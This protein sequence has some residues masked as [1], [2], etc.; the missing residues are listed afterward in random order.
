MYIHVP[1]KRKFSWQYLIKKI[2]FTPTQ[3]T[4]S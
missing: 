1:E 3:G 2:T 4:L